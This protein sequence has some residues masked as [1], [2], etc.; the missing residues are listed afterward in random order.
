MFL[1]WTRLIQSMLPTPHLEHPFWYYP[2]IYAWVSHVV[3]F[4]YVSPQKF[5]MYLLS[6]PSCHF[7]RPSHYSR[8]EHPSNICW[9][10]QIIKLLI[11]QFSPLPVIPSLLG[12]NFSLS[13]L[14]SNTLRLRHSLNV[15]D[16]VSHPYKT[17][18]K[19]VVLYILILMR[20]DSKLK[21]TRFCSEK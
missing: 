15:C 1:I 4:P 7:Y 13:T 2:P 5:C 9:R 12:P 21:D 11:M 8:F 18:C 20:L 3:S 6:L 14:F 10:I 16:Q 19:T 17:T